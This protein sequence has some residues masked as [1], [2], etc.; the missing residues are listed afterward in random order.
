MMAWIRQYGLYFAWVVSLVATGGSLYF[1]EIALFEPCKLCWF[2]RIFMYP[3]TVLLG[4]ASYRDDRRIIPYT[5]PLSVIGGSISFYHYL[6]QKVPAMKSFTPCTQGVP[7]T[8]DYINWFGFVTIPFMALT[9]FVLITWFLMAARTVE[10]D[11]VDETATE[12]EA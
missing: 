2:Q 8:G 5:L 10:S 12:Q 1:S 7:C 9:A 4:I 11:K 3:L 6:L